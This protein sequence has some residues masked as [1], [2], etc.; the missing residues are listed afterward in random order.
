MIDFLS[1]EIP[2]RIF[3]YESGIN[4]VTEFYCN[5]ELLEAP[6][7][8][9]RNQSSSLSSPA[10]TRSSLTEIIPHLPDEVLA[11]IN[12][13]YSHDFAAFC[14]P[15]LP[16]KRIANETLE[17]DP[18]RA[19]D[20]GLTQ[21]IA[22]SLALSNHECISTLASKLAR[23]RSLVKDA[24]KQDLESFASQLKSEAVTTKAQLDQLAAER[25]EERQQLND[26]RSK[27]DQMHA[28][29][30]QA[31]EELEKK[32][33]I[34]NECQQNLGQALQELNWNRNQLKRMA[35]IAESNFE[36]QHRA[37]EIITRLILATPRASDPGTRK[38]YWP[39]AGKRLWKSIGCLFSRPSSPRLLNNPD[40]V[41]LPK[42]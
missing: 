28:K 15:L 5:D 24:R 7:M 42:Q 26:A 34:S 27:A 8:G 17:P 1:A 36:Y 30:Q 13:Y 31:L 35:T 9:R 16:T 4:T 41:A 2:C 29:L 11:L 22:N 33:L 3:R 25:Q 18:R 20:F 39:G 23:L 21:E 10:R 37:L 6:P 12:D 40:T 32:C 19:P 38:G 14:Y